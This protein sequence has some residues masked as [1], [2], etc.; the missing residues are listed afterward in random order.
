MTNYELVIIA[1]LA[2]TL[3]SSLY[4]N[5]KFDKRSKK[6]SEKSVYIDTS[7]LI[8]GR[9]LPIAE[10]GFFPGKMIIPRSVIA[11]LQFLADNGDSEKRE[12]ARKGLDVAKELQS[13]DSVDAVLV[14]DSTAKGEGVDD[15][16]LAIVRAKGGY[17]CTIDY[18]LN[19]VAQVEG[20]K[21]LNINEL[22]KQLRMSYLPGEKV[23]IALTG[24]GTDRHQAVGHLGDGTMVVVEQASSRI[25]THVEVEIIRSIQTAAGK[26]MFAKLVQPVAQ[27]KVQKQR[28]QKPSGR[29]PKQQ[30]I[31][32]RRPQAKKQA[33]T[34]D[35]LVRLAN[36][37][38]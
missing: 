5:Y 11:E 25:G 16:L 28:V 36:G 3:L 12:R 9:I 14:D 2:I 37:Q 26:M 38:E 18:N 30:Q 13:L 35:S 17:L 10:T 6:T 34:E 29:L 15:K 24:T 7:V 27:Q 1:L 33:T 8:D 23:Q 31:A 4:T 22:A 21:V 19:K 32:S 20:I